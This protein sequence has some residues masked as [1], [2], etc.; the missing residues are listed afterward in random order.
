MR[1]LWSIH[2]LKKCFAPRIFGT[3]VAHVQLKLFYEA[4]KYYLKNNHL[5]TENKTD[6]M[7]VTVEGKKQQMSDLIRQIVH[8]SVGLT[9][10]QVGSVL[11]EFQ[12]AIEVSLAQGDTVETDLFTVQPRIRGVFNS[13]NEPFD[14]SKHA[15]YI[16][17]KPSGSLKALASQ[18]PVERITAPKAT[19]QPEVCYNLETNAVNETL[20]PDENARVNGA[21]LKFDKNDPQQGVF[22]I[23]S[24]G[25]ATPVVKFTDIFPKQLT[26]RVPKG[27]AKGDYQ[28]EVRSTLGSQEVRSGKLSGLLA[29]Q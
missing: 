6:L 7:A 9:E 10:S 24:A 23:N 12:S 3:P 8:R 4:M 5:T 11:K 16:K 28:L 26:F 15:V 18:L 27:L 19:P 2:D 21:N 13:P 14:R 22:L 25:E 20:T 1:K 29:V 17:M